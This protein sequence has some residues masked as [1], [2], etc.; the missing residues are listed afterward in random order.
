MQITLSNNLKICVEGW[1]N[2]HNIEHPLN[3]VSRLS[4]FIIES[5]FSLSKPLVG[6]SKK[7]IRGSVI[8]SNPIDILF[9][10]PPDSYGIK[11]PPTILS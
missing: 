4:N 1:C 2:V 10:S 5:A 9:L 3:I 6:S 8:I 7:T 11:V